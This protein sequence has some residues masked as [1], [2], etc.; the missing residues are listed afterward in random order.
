MMHMEPLNQVDGKPRP[1]NPS[2]ARD[3]W[4]HRV[5]FRAM[6]F[7]ELDGESPEKAVL[8]A[9]NEMDSDPLT[10]GQRWA[11]RGFLTLITVTALAFVIPVTM[12][13]VG[14]VVTPIWHWG[15]GWL[16]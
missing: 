8:R 3:D 6:E 1:A 4:R 7:I 14:Y 12:W 10:K 15:L 11:M 13:V 16:S 5:A 2:G 9:L